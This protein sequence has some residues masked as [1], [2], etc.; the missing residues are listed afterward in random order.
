MP[1]SPTR[2]RARAAST[3]TASRRAER[4]R[5]STRMTRTASWWARSS[6]THVETHARPAHLP[7]RLPARGARRSRARNDADPDVTDRFELFVAGREIA[8]AFSEL[9]DPDDQRA[10]FQAPGRG[11]G[12][13]A[14]RRR[15]TT[16]RTT[17]RALEHGMP[18]TAGEGI[19]IDRLAML[20]TDAAVDPRRH[21]VPADAARVSRPWRRGPATGFE[22]FVAW[23]YLR[24]PR[25][26]LPSRVLHHRAG[27][28]WRWRS[29]PLALVVRQLKGAAGRR[30]DSWG[31]PRIGPEPQDRRA[32]RRVL[33]D[34]VLL[35][36]AALAQ[37][38]GLHRDLDL[39]RLPGDVRRPS[40]RCR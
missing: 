9:N 29:S 37:L 32:R 38:H 19:G 28:C 7:H 25:A 3:P 12:S 20:L 27:R 10:R 36:R 14:P 5:A 13:A 15:W 39:R 11:Q 24:D 2:L 26:S 17:C 6:S 30:G 16:T 35:R 4:R 21:P 33:G 1:D 18:P 34:F 22:W 8:N 31:A 40:S 23:R